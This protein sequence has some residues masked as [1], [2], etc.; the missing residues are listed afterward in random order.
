MWSDY[1]HH[2]AFELVPRTSGTVSELGAHVVNG[3]YRETQKMRD[4][5]T[6]GYAEADERVNTQIGIELAVFGNFDLGV[7]LQ[8]CVEFLYEIREKVQER[9]IESG[10]KL[11]LF[12]FHGKIFD[13]LA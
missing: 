2:L 1:L 10:I 6:V 8:Q 5:D 3:G 12:V 9:G 7:V 13:N 11:F 4:F